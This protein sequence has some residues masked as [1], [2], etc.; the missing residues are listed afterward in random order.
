MKRPL[1]SKW[2]VAAHSQILSDD[3][4]MCRSNTFSKMNVVFFFFLVGS[5][6]VLSTGGNEEEYVKLLPEWTA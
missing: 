5:P 3:I 1:K 6:L 4:W 2:F